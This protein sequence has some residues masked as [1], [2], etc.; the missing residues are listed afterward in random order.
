M[1]QTLRQMVETNPRPG[2]YVAAAKTLRTVG[3]ERS[4]TALLRQS[5]Q[6][7]PDNAEIR[8]ALGG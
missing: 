1:A 3:D 7:W 5:L 6:R 2:A 8:E 4:A